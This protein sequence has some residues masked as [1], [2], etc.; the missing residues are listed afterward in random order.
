MQNLTNPQNDVLTNPDLLSLILN[1]LDNPYDIKEAREVSRL[2]RSCYKVENILPNNKEYIL[3]KIRDPNSKI[4]NTLQK[5]KTFVKDGKLFYTNSHSG[6]KE[7]IDKIIIVHRFSKEDDNKSW[8]IPF[9]G[10][11]QCKNPLTIYN[12]SRRLALSTSSQGFNISL[13]DAAELKGNNIVYQKGFPFG[14][15]RNIMLTVE[16]LMNLK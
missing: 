5:L 6:N 1:N 11:Y 12:R 3:S 10:V 2:W 16:E 15:E 13:R 9:H 8:V 7:S 14:I 4:W